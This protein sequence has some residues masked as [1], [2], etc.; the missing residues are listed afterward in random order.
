MT[1]EQIEF[2]MDVAE[3]AWCRP[4]K[5]GGKIVSHGICLRHLRQLGGRPLPTARR[6]RTKK[7]VDHSS[8]LM[9]PLGLPEL[10]TA[11]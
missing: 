8:D 5:P 3:C 7:V 10:A 11:S 6:P 9:L 2:A 1:G 4:P